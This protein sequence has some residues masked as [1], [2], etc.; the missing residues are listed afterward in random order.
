[1]GKVFVKN[2]NFTQHAISSPIQS[3][4]NSWHGEQQVS[5]MPQDSHKSLYN[6]QSDTSALYMI[7]L[8]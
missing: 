1:M 4:Q 2:D 5:A 7:L 6:I 3:T 8:V